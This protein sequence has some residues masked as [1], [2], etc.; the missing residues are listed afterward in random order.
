MITKLLDC[1]LRDGGYVN[2]WNFGAENIRSIIA[3]LTKA[4]VDIVECGFLE[5][6]SHSDSIS[7]YNSMSKIKTFLPGERGRTEYVAM[8]EYGKYPLDKL[9]VFDGGAV[10]GIRVT[11]HK[12]DIENSLMFC[13]GIKEKGY[14][15]YY[16]PVGIDAYKDREFL[17]LVEKANMLT[18]YSFYIVDTSGLMVEKD[19]QKIYHML[20]SN[21]D[22]SISIGFHSHN[23][24]QLSFS[25]SQTFFNIYSNR[26]K[27]IDSSVYGMGRGAG[28]LCT[29]LMA[30]YINNQ[31][32]IIYDVDCI[33]EI[34][35]YHIREIRKKFEWGYSIPLYLAA[36]H[37]CHPNYAIFLAEKALQTNEVKNILMSILPERRCLFDYS[38]ITALYLEHQNKQTGETNKDRPSQ[39]SITGHTKSGV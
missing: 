37:K 13:A 21:L 28:N 32:E 39:F 26:E 25:N 9:E 27:I 33:L 34:Y 19:L 12:N 38:Y 20:E 31:K 15:V 23:N 5:D 36:L 24:L 4:N 11:F 6:T 17:E 14:K 2:D 8:I 10:T 1:T 30:N 3:M 22:A 7:I 16:Q 18:P 29:E 35:E